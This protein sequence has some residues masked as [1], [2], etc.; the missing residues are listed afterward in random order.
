VFL[1]EPRGLTAKTTARLHGPRSS[2][3]HIASSSPCGGGRFCIVALFP[4]ARSTVGFTPTRQ[5]NML[6]VRVNIRPFPRFAETSVASLWFVGEGVFR[7]QVT[8]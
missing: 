4:T 3:T 6:S 1:R 7:L 5:P 8:S 2:F